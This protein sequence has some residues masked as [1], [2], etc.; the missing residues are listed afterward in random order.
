MSRFPFRYTCIYIYTVAPGLMGWFTGVFFLACFVVVVVLFCSF[1]FW[2]Y[3]GI[4]DICNADN[5]LSLSFYILCFVI[6]VGCWI[7]AA[8]VPL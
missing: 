7:A 2:F 5:T 4:L 6:C 3:G 1:L 8:A